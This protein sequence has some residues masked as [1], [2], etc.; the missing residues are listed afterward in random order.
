MRASLKSLSS[1]RSLKNLDKSGRSENSCEVSTIEK[2]GEPVYKNENT[3]TTSF[4]QVNPIQYVVQ[5]PQVITPAFRPT[6]LLTTS[7]RDSV[8]F[9]YSTER[10]SGGFEVPKPPNIIGF[11]PKPPQPPYMTPVPPQR[12]VTQ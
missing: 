5:T 7:S 8:R 1:A 12:P 10:N 9:S 6:S 3:V 11:P 2:T 4:V